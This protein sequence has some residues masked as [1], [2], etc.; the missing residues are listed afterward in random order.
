MCANLAYIYYLYPIVV[1]ITV[2]PEFVERR[3]N[4]VDQTIEFVVRKSGLT[5]RA[6][7]VIAFTRNSSLT[8]IGIHHERIMRKNYALLYTSMSC[9]WYEL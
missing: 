2:S 5:E 7:E 1:N 6:V 9:L 3:E 8:G 4:E